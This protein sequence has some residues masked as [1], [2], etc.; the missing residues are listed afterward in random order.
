M[1]GMHGIVLLGSFDVC[2]GYQGCEG[3]TLQVEEEPSK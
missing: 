3:A 1:D 2:E